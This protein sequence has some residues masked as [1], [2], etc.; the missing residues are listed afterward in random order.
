MIY[1]HVV[2]HNGKYYAVGEDVPEND[3]SIL[4]DKNIA[5]DT[6]SVTEEKMAAKR[7]RPKKSQ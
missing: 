5:F 4:P 2:K 6:N 3:E 7:G 1:D